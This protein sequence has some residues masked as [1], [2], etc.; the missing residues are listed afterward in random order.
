VRVARQSKANER[1]PPNLAFTRRCAGRLRASVPAVAFARSG[2]P[3]P[4]LPVVQRVLHS[5]GEKTRRNG[6]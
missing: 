6:P 3:V 5:G 1:S 2:R 4:V